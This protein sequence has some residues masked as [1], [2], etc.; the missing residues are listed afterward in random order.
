M[1]L[2]TLNTHSLQE[3]GYP[4]KLEQFVSVI[5]KEKPDLIALQEVNQSVYAQL[6]KSELL[7]GWVSCPDGIRIGQDNHAAQTAFRLWKAG[8]DCSWTWISAKIGYGIYDEGMALL[9]LNRKIAEVE[10]F[11]IS[12]CQDYQ[13]WKTRRVLGVRMKGCSHW[14]YTVHMGWWQ[15][16]EEPFLEQWKR[17][18]MT[19]EQKKEAGAVWLLGDFNSP[20]EFRG[21]GYDCICQSG[22]QD[23]YQLAEQKDSGITVEGCID[24]WR[25][26]SQEQTMPKGMRMD[27]IWCSQKLPVK[28]S[29]VLF[30]GE[31]EAKVSDHF[32]VLIEADVDAER[33]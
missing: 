23:T 6:A 11:F 20:A 18:N 15:D 27:G 19:L 22:W 26:F 25:E 3:E 1:K 31:N 7:Q 29:K 21:Q 2:L 5:Q 4:Q 8:I 14:F 12:S 9:C 10:S 33:F 24:G 32:G 16:E 13:N 30:N 17:L 28:Y